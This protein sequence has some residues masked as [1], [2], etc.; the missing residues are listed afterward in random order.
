MELRDYLLNGI[1]GGDLGS[2]EI[3]YTL[4]MAAVLSVYVFFVYRMITRKTFYSRS[5]NVSLAAI[6]VITSAIILTIQSSLVVSLGMVGALSIVRFRTAVKEPMDL[7]FLFWSIG[8]GIMTGAGMMKLAVFLSLV[9][10]ILILVLEFIPVA[11]SPM[12]LVVNYESGEK[13]DEEVLEAIRRHCRFFRVK[14]RNITKG[15][16]DLVYEIRTSEE[17]QLAEAVTAVNGVFS[18]SVLS[19]DGEVSL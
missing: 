13:T 4:G 9:L 18:V 6:A 17:R 2:G 5:F 11:K 15:S 8:I 16:T 10:T 12:I 7:A 3:L 19:H 1:S 14:S